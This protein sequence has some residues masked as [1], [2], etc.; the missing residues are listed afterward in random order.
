MAM[1]LGDINAGDGYSCNQNDP[2][3]WANSVSPTSALGQ[4]YNQVCIQQGNQASAV[5][6]GQAASA[7][8]TTTQ[9]LPSGASVDT[10]IP[11]SILPPGAAA[12][13]ITPTNWLRIAILA[14]LGLGLGIG[15]WHY[16]R[17]KAAAA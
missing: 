15:V 7:N 2:N 8:V 12:Q 9:F 1:V 14:A 6:A 10:S 5:A 17:R 16:T 11:G 4:A 3:W 13:T